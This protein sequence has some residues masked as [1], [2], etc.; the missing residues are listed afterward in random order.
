MPIGGQPVKLDGRRV[1]SMRPVTPPTLR[2]CLGLLKCF[3]APGLSG[4]DCLVNT[5]RQ[6]NGVGGDWPKP[7][8]RL[9]PT[10]SNQLILTSNENK[11]GYTQ[12]AR[13]L[14]ST[15]ESE[16]ED[17]LLFCDNDEKTEG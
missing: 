6:K 9:N 13:H 16:S 10:K 11:R 1:G 3:P 14:P 17:A 8:I 7:I 12:L 2:G 15:V 5:I 4:F